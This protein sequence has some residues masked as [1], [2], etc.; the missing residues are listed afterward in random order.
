ANQVVVLAYGTWKGMFGADPG[1]VG[2][3]IE[4]NNQ[5]YKVVGV[6][7]QDFRWPKEADLWTPLGLARD[8]FTEANRF[9]ENLTAAARLRP[10]VPVARANAVIQVL[11]DRVRNNGTRG[12]AYAKDAGWG[13]FAQPIADSIAGSS[14]KPMLVLA[15]AVGLVL[16][17]ACANIAG[18]MLV[19][20]SARSRE[21]AVR[22][23]LGAGRWNLVRQTMWDSGLLALG[24]GVL[25]VGLAY[26]GIQLLPL[27]APAKFAAGLMVNID[28]R[29]LL[30]TAL[31][32]LTAAILAGVAPAWQTSRVER[33]DLLKEGGRSGT[34]GRARQRMR[35]ALVVGEVALALVLL[36]GAGL[37]L[38]SLQRLQDVG[39][40]FEPRQVMTASVSLPDTRYQEPDKKVALYRDVLGRLS[41][42]PGVTSAAAAV[43]LPFSGMGGSASFSIEGRNVG[44]GDPG[45]HG[46]VRYV[47]P[48]FLATLKIPIKAGR[49]FTEQDRLGT[50]PVVAI[51]E[52]LARQYFQ[53]ENPI[54]QH[55]R[56]GNRAPWSTIVG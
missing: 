38:R 7:R 29:V 42:L 5:P 20:G 35:S 16:L 45:P 4:L 54:G 48:G 36:I 56:R 6:M 47:T 26:L 10:G 25:G 31:I 24:G 46:D 41:A 39:T 33:F 3:T 22:A 1:I 34:T 51:D 15:G 18:L 19:R 2:R 43:L 14:K 37:F 32:A 12:G 40:G 17:I 52:N 53:G 27:L 21:M 28:E 30:F 23:A 50:E 13:M 44:P 55:L 9:N 8:Q 49:V 11:T